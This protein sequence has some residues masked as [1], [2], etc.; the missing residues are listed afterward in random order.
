MRPDILLPIVKDPKHISVI[1]AG[2][3]GKH[4]SWPP[5]FGN[6]IELPLP[7]AGL[8]ASGMRFSNNIFASVVSTHVLQYPN[9]AVPSLADYNAY[10]AGKSFRFNGTSY[11]TLAAPLSATGHGLGS[12]AVSTLGCV[13]ATDVHLRSGSPLNNVDRVNGLTTVGAPRL[14]L[15]RPWCRS[16]LEPAR[17]GVPPTP[18]SSARGA[19]G[20]PGA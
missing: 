12:P 13:G 6:G 16:R 4:S 15:G 8:T 7:N 2:G 19:R 3:A 10:S 11:S 1:V 20:P 9:D 18:G 17:P 5:T 14:D